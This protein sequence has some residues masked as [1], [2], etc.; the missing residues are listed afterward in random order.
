MLASAQLFYLATGPSG[1]S[2]LFLGFIS[3]KWAQAKGESFAYICDCY[4]REWRGYLIPCLF[5][6]L[7]TT[8]HS[9]RQERIQNLRVIVYSHFA[10]IFSSQFHISL[11]VTDTN[12]AIIVINNN[13]E[14]SGY[15]RWILNFVM[16]QNEVSVCILGVFIGCLMKLFLWILLWLVFCHF[17]QIPNKCW[18]ITFWWR[19]HFWDL[20]GRRKTPPP[21][22]IAFYFG[23]FIPNTSTKY[24]VSLY[25]S[26]FNS[27]LKSLVCTHILLKPCR[28]FTFSNHS[29][30]PFSC[31][32]LMW[33]LLYL[34]PV[35]I[36]NFYAYKQFI[37]HTPSI[38]SKT[39]HLCK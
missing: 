27:L 35:N 20:Q 25:I 37:I 30:G 26:I 19:T 32:M 2:F 10:S 1:F 4:F 21:W 14:H 31:Q 17:L 28:L 18:L 22:I 6:L 34:I 24:N 23:P 33:H 29:Y 12:L 36:R 5:C 8:S 13:R 39:C 16:I 11:T 15:S 38:C 9:S 7:P 3:G